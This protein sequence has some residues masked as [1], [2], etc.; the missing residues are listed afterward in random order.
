M[1]KQKILLFW[2]GGK[3][4]NL[5]LTRLKKSDQ[6]EVAGLVSIINPTKNTVKHHGI[7]EALLVDQAKLLDMPLIRIYLEAEATNKEYIDVVGKKLLPFTSK[8]IKHFAFGDIHSEE[9][10]KFR[11]K[12][13]EQLKSDA[14]FPLWGERSEKLIEEYFELNH[15]SIITSID[16]NKLDNS[17]LAKLYDREWIARLPSNIDPMGENGE[18]HT[19]ATYS[20]YFRMRIPFSKTIAI[21]EGP[22]TVSLLKEP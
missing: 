13:C 3:D 8:N 21:E 19:F 9:N 1:E 14:I 7:P 17:Y 22:Y 15:Q 2:S 16:R 20:P 12:M 4:S 10:K 11:I 18:F 6:Y 5:A